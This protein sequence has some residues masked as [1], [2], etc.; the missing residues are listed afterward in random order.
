[1]VRGKPQQ[2][3]LR[4]A[5]LKAKTYIHHLPNMRHEYQQLEHNIQYQSSQDH[6][7]HMIVKTDFVR[8]KFVLQT[9][10]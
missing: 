6:H 7:H 10:E 4:L 8:F 5:S 2:S 3:Q 1:M 9:S